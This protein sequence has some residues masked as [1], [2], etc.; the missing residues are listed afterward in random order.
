MRTLLVTGG[1]GFIGSAFLRHVVGQ[2]VRAVN[3]DKLTYAANPDA[4]A[5]LGDE[6]YTFVKAD[7]GDREAIRAVFA[8]HRPDGV[9][10]HNKNS[11]LYT[12]FHHGVFFQLFFY[13]EKI[14]I[15]YFTTRPK[16]R[17]Y[18]LTL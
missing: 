4:V 6:S 14:E 12:Q 13:F 10:Y 3:V 17:K 11:F 1:C 2:G 15:F 8:K 5:G 16:N 9:V 7:I 18:I